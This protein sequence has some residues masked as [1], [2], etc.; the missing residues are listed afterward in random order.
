MKQGFF[1]SKNYAVFQSKPLGMSQLSP[2]ENAE[3]LLHELKT[4]SL[5]QYFLNS[6]TTWANLNK[7]TLLPSTQYFSFKN[8]YLSY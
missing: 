1:E 8:V 3:N 2:A 5:P 7:F 6:F 4:L